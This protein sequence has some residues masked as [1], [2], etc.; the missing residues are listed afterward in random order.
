[1]EEASAR[2]LLHC[3]APVVWKIP[4]TN[5]PADDATEVET[6]E[7]EARPYEQPGEGQVFKDFLGVQ[8]SRDCLGH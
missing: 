7:T 5:E 1:M 4:E 8:V 6:E 2:G 3:G